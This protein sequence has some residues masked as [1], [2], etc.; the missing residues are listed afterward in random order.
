ME[1]FNQ[2]S[3][4]PEKKEGAVGTDQG[5]PQVVTVGEKD[6]T[7]EDIQGMLDNQAASTQKLQEICSNERSYRSRAY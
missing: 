6:Y 7:P 3:S 1:K 2:G 4:E 5:T